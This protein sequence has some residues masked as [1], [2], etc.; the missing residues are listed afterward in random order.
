MITVRMIQYWNDYHKKELRE[1]FGGLGELAD[2]IFAQMRVDYT[3]ESG[4]NMLS[5]P[6]CDTGSSIYEISVR[7]EY[8]G[9][10][11]WIKLIEDEDSGIIFSDGTFTAGQKHCTKAVR[12]WLAGC[13]DRRKNPTFHFA[14]DDAETGEDFKEDFM[15]GRVIR[16][17]M[18]KDNKNLNEDYISGRLVK[19]AIRKIH[20]AGGC[21]ANDEYSKGYDDAITV[22]LNILLEETGYVLEDALDDEVDTE[23]KTV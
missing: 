18:D 9:Y 11:F 7:P 4:K 16:Y 20:N 17:Y 5:F 12:E 23:D 22:A 2:W 10:V 13:E 8:G 15:S 6:K 3:S 19:S 14:S 21:D 1:R